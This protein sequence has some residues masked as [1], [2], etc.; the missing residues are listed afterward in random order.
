MHFLY[1]L[2]LNKRDADEQAEL[3]DV[4]DEAVLQKRDEYKEVEMTGAQALINQGK[5]EGRKEGR[6]EGRQEGRLEILLEQLEAKFGPL[7][8]ATVASVNALPTNR[9]S[10]ITR[11]ILTAASLAELEL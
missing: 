11:R 8:E 2:I 6:Q 1:L 3:K 9:L 5:R 4:M 10:A 7:S